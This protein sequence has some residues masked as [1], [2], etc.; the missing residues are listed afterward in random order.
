MA[1][2]EQAKF[3][4]LYVLF[5]RQH[6]TGKIA[7]RHENNKT[8]TFLGTGCALLFGIGVLVPRITATAG[9]FIDFSRLS[10]PKI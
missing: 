5:L 3:S 6:K 4:T 7:S 9:Q 2:T 1:Q 10:Y 8:I